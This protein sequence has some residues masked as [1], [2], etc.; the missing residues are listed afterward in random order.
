[1]YLESMHTYDSS[2]KE[3]KE[4]FAALYTLNNRGF[5]FINGNFDSLGG[6]TDVVCLSSIYSNDIKEMDPSRHYSV[7][8]LILLLGSESNFGHCVGLYVLY[9]KHKLLAYQDK[10]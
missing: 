5:S 4:Y 7:Q 9:R 8:K 6:E 10:T 3:R 2:I 1:M